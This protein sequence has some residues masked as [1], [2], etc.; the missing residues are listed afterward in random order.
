MKLALYALFFLFVFNQCAKE[1]ETPLWVTIDTWDLEDN[2]FATGQGEMTSNITEAWVNVNNKVIGVFEL[3]I[4]IPIIGEPGDFEFILIPGVKN[5]GIN[6]T[7]IRYPFMEQYTQTISLT[8]TDTAYLKPTTRYYENL[9]FFVEDFEDPLNIKIETD[10]ISNCNLVTSNDPS[11][12]AYGNY[13]GHIP[14][15]NTDSLFSGYTNAN[16]GLDLP[17]GTD[18]F[19]EIDYH[20]TNTLLTTVLGITSNGVDEEPHIQLNAQENPV[21][22]KIYIDLKEIVSFQSADTYQVGFTAI[23]NELGTEKDIYIDNVKVIYN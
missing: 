7:K 19:L 17:T 18:V 5:N 11:V 12:V 13:C 14:L 21:W 10:P 4:K 1:V 2:P 6:A 20:N 15:N 3:P 16:G 9:T 8:K 22:K 23:L